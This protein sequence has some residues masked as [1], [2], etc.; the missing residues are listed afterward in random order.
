MSRIAIP[1]LVDVLPVDD[2][3]AIAAIASDRRFDRQYVRRGPML[4][5]IILGRVRSIL[6]LAGAPLP[7][8]AEHGPVRPAPSQSATQARLDALATGGLAGPDIDALAAYVRGEGGARC[9]GK[10]AQQAVGRLF[11]PNYRADDESWSAALILRD[12]PS[13]FNP[14][15]R[16]IWALTGRIAKARALLAEKVNQDP[17]G[18]HGTG[19]AI[20]NLAE[21]FSR[22][23]TLYSD[24]AAR[25]QNS[26]AAAVA[27]SIVAPKQV[28]RQPNVAGTCPAGPFTKDTLVLLQ[29][30]RANVR[31]PGYDMAFMAGSWSACPA[32]GWVPALMAT[33]WRRAIEGTAA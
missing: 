24:P 25:D 15:K 2:A 18:L 12:A 26:P 28:L 7:P 3:A 29:L 6:T 9:G 22:M 16:L 31:T 13:S 23:R 19:V 32:Q 4:N 27:A 10:L 33:V 8:V 11:D 21:A 1:G 30:E 20:H 5:R 14:V 17:T